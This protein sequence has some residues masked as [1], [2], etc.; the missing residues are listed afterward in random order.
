MKEIMD[1]P[2]ERAAHALHLFDVGEACGCNRTRG[3]EMLK[4]RA[5]APGAHA[6]DLIERI[7]ADRLCTLLAMTADGKAMSFVPE[8]LQVIEN[9]ALGIEAERLLAGHVEMFA[10]R[11]AIRAL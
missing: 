7:G 9:R 8:P 11:L 2:R 1:L 10:S 3:A 6:L 4:Q 5:L